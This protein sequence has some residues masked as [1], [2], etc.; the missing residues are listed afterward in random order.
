MVWISRLGNVGFIW[1]AISFF[2]L[3]TPAR[4]PAAWRLI[5][6]VIFTWLVADIALKAIFGRPRPFD[7]VAG[8][9]LLSTRPTDSSFPSAHAA[10]GFAGA[11]AG[12][13][14]FPGA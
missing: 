1:F 8:I 11:L 6:T 9:Q 7:V 10:M 12:S 4:R 2:G 5:L 14:V 13:R 3:L